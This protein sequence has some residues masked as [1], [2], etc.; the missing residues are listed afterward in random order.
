V[1]W[2]L[3]VLRKY[4]QFEGRA[5][6][7]EF[8]LFVLVN[9]AISLALGILDAI[10]GTRGDFGGLLQGVYG[11]AVLIPSLAVG[12]RRLHDI[13][14]SGWWQLLLLIPL[15]GLIILIVWWAKEGDKAPNDHGPD[16]WAGPQPV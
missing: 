9:V 11:L 14:R 12:A 7:T 2:Y 15:V 3:E 8:W 13:G 6:R 5:H 16:P 4:A 10:L 1:Q